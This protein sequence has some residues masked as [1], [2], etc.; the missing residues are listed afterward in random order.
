M[1]CVMC[2]CGSALSMHTPLH[3]TS[4]VR[5]I[6]YAARPPWWR[7][8]PQGLTGTFGALQDLSFYIALSLPGRPC[9]IMFSL[10]REM[11]MDDGD[12][13]PSFREHVVRVHAFTGVG[14]HLLG[15][16]AAMHPGISSF[17]QCVP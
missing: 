3:A 4:G 16:A 10:S 12:Q 17:D 2:G 8:W 7:T 9:A 5:L 6:R 11:M 14:L 13:P 15:C 1:P